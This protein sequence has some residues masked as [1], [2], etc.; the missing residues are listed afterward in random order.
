VAR[1]RARTRPR[2]LIILGLLAGLAL[3]AAARLPGWSHGF[4]RGRLAAFFHRPVSIGALRWELVPRP[5]VTIEALRVAGPTP[6]APAFLEARRMVLVPRLRPFW[7]RRALL[8]RLHA[9][10]LR[11]RIS[12]HRDG[13]HDLPA[14]D[15]GGAGGREVRV[16]RL[17]VEDSELFVNDQRVPLELS[18]HDVGARL[19]GSRKMLTGRVGIGRGELRFGG[20]PPLPLSLEAELRLQGPRLEVKGARVR[21]SRTDVLA[22]GA[23]DWSRRLEGRFT[24]KGE[25]DLGVMERYVTRTG[26]GLEGHGTTEGTLELGPRGLTFRGR[27]SGRDG[28]FQ[29]VA[30]P[31]FAGQ[32]AW[33]TRALHLRDLDV[34]T[35]GGAATVQ[36]E[37]PSGGGQATMEAQFAR[38]D[39]EAL[40][41]FVFGVGAPGVGA[42]ASGEAALSWPRGRVRDLSG[43][44]AL[45]LAASAD[46]RTP[47]WGR[48]AWRARQGEQHVDHAD[49]RTPF[50]QARLSGDIGR[51]LAADLAVDGEASDLGAGDALLVRIRRALGAADPRS[52]EITGGGRFQ[53]RWRGTLGAPVLEGRFEG[54]G[55]GYRGV[56]WGRAEWA[57]TLTGVDVRSHSLVLRRQD[58][59]LWIDGA[60]ELGDYGLRDSVDL[61]VRVVRWPAEDLLAALGWKLDFRGTVS[62]EAE[63]KGRRSAPLGSFRLAAASGRY[64]GVPFEDLELDGRLRG[65]A[66]EVRRAQA[67]VGGGEARFLGWVHDDGVYDLQADLTDVDGSA[68][69]ARAAPRIRWSGPLTGRMVLQGTRQRPRVT[70]RV[71]SPRVVVAGETLGAVDAT[72]SGSGDGQLGIEARCRSERTEL[73]LTGTVAAAPPYLGELSVKA[74]RA[75][76]LPLLRAS[77]PEVPEGVGGTA[78]G[79]ARLRGPLQEPRAMTG[80][81][82]IGA[83]ALELPDYPVHTRAPLRAALRDGGLELGAVRL[84]GEGTDLTVG[85]RIP[86]SADEPLEVTLDGAADLRVVSLLLPELKGR[87]AARLGVR[88]SGTLH[89]PRLDGTLNV[90]G[91]TLRARGFPHGIEDVRGVVR[92]TEGGAEFKEMRATVGGGPVE[93]SGEATYVRARMRSFDVRARGQGMALRYPEGLRSVVDADLRLFGDVEHQWLTGRVDLRQAVWTRRYDVAS[94]LMAESRPVEEAAT[95]E[96]SLRL[97]IKVVAPG[98][99]RIDNNLAQLTA[100]ADLTVQGTSRAPVVL[101]RAEVERGRVFFQGNTYLIRR[102]ALEF[103]NPRRIDPLFD[104]EAEARVRSYRVTLRMNGTLDR[105]YPTLSADPYLSTVQILSLLAGADEATVDSFSTAAA[106]DLA[107]TRLAAAGA[108]TL[109]AGRLSEEVGLERGAA[110]LGLDRFSIDP[111]LVRGD[112]S[113]PTARV[114]LGKRVT[115]DVNILYSLDLRGT[116]ERLVSV[117][118]TLSDRLSILMTQVE[119]GGFGFDLRV[120]QSR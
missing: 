5:R 100:R 119:P 61:R 96:G 64:L 80:E 107:Q 115:S 38:L 65:R 104:I 13:G 83:L 50:A 59:E 28:M 101:G 40:A 39:A 102:G 74:P 77:L 51:G 88:V 27:V 111:S 24:V 99:V 97:D 15:L 36:V 94:E 17:I 56:A 110:R 19:F 53:G 55:V 91:A 57:G 116:E 20:A 71:S 82:E 23:V 6:D 89:E 58:G 79:E 48:L 72:V 73:M 2:T 113:D 25:V 81:V 93:A 8:G 95:R 106:R 34:E 46:G 12:A 92:F 26:L 21:A 11:V 60:S 44:V 9:T 43:T 62:G 103:A 29:Q 76:L 112:V 78:A 69:T 120:R 32:L 109:A 42:E 16:D 84:A 41:S 45:D 90:D 3:V 4:V 49:L 37:L 7:E 22:D 98:T 33:D 105:V 63:V 1:G 117:E 52:A 66:T 86:L 54:E 108:A 18:W 67:R 85:G 47:L 87:G 30:V 118:Y 75:D 114:T 70:A 10:G 35:L 14:F 68:L 31:V